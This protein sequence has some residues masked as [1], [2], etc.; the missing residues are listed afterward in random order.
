MFVESFENKNDLFVPVIFSES[1]DITTA[2]NIQNCTLPDFISDIGKNTISKEILNFG[3]NSAKNTWTD[4]PDD[5]KALVGRELN[6]LCETHFSGSDDLQ[7][8]VYKTMIE[9]WQKS[10]LQSIKG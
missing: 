8:R 9:L 7:N 1:A 6:S 2:N 3:T 4:I 10:N 5:D